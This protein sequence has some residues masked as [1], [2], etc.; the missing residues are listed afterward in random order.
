MQ[1][2]KLLVVAGLLLFGSI[3]VAG[4]IASHPRGSLNKEEIWSLIQQWRQEQG[5]AQYAESERVCE[6]ASIRLREVQQQFDHSKFRANRFCE[7]GEICK[8]AENLAKGQSSAE[9]VVNA[10]LASPVHAINLNGSF[11]ESCIKTDGYH[12]VHIFATYQ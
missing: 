6:V 2:S 3:L 5:Y 9:E 10:W 8:I 4:F 7:D 1:K 11:R 12:V